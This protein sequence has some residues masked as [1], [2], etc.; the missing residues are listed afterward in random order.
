MSCIMNK[1]RFHL[2]P[3]SVV[4][5]LLLLSGCNLPGGDDCASEDLPAPIN[6]SPS[7]G[8]VID[9]L[10]P[11]VT[12]EYIG[13]C[14][15]EGFNIVLRD[16]TGEAVVL[17]SETVDS[18]TEDWSPTSPLS[19]ASVY[20]VEITPFSGSTTG[21][22]AEEIFRTGP[23]CAAP[24]APTLISPADGTVVDEVGEIT[25]WPS[26][27]VIDTTPSFYMTWEGEVDCIPAEGYEIQVSNIVSFPR[28]AT[29]IYRQIGSRMYFFFPPGMDRHWHECETYFW[30]V[31]PL[32]AGDEGG[33]PSEAWSFTIN[34]SGL[35]CP[36]D[37]RIEPLIPELDIGIP[38]AG[39]GAIAGHVWH[40]E[41]ATPEESTDTAPPGCVIL[42]DGSIEANGEL[43]GGEYGIEGV[44]VRL[45]AGA[46]P[47]EGDWTSVTDVSGHYGFY[48]LLAGTYCLAIDPEADGND[49]V[50]L[51]GHWTVP[52]RWYGPGPI[53]VDVTLGSD[54]DI[55]RLN[56]F[57]WD[58]QYLPVPAERAYMLTATIN[59]NCRLGPGLN[60]EAV[61]FLL[62]G[63]Q[64]AANA[65]NGSNTWWRVYLLSILGNCWLSDATVD[66]PF[67]PVG[68]PIVE[69]SPPTA[70][71]PACTANLEEAACAAAGGT[72]YHGANA[73]YCICP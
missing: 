58:Y 39:H 13:T 45:S 29:N 71:P 40:D 4:I 5:L 35:L 31:I 7:G 26:G 28:A 56:D 72:Y 68:L 15:P 46:C 67:D 11:D 65:R 44:T 23:I 54:D 8:E 20:D 30:R 73:E 16:L 66:A 3:F 63:E 59:A 34:T 17:L 18:M 57:A 25:A 43:D 61:G 53:S 27:E 60:Y 52:E 19:P 12:W 24:A 32:L 2:L 55:S 22:G 21:S 33:P 41:C 51:P 62:E 36:P 38:I 1:F 47:G 49:A 70:E 69:V 14:E 50:L 9:G 37:L 64:A 48:D 6:L 10:A 42:P